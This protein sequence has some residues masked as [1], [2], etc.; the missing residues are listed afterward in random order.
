VRDKSFLVYF[1][2]AMSSVSMLRKALAQR[3]IA[4]ALNK[5]L[6]ALVFLPLSYL[7][8]HFVFFPD[9]DHRYFVPQYVVGA[10]AL[11]WIMSASKI[12]A[13]SPANERATATPPQ[14]D[15]E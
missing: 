1:C 12:V 2:V 7:I 6:Y 9:L 14:A 3:E 13:I 15:P 8:L 5:D 10:V 11:F 4:P